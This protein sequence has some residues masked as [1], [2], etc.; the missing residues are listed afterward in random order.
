QAFG[1]LVG[2]RHLLHPEDDWARER[3]EAAL[4][5]SAGADNEW[6]AVGV[7]FAAGHL[8]EEPSYRARA[9]ELLCQLVPRPSERVG[10]AVMAVYQTRDELPLDEAALR[11]LRDVGLHPDILV[12]SG[13]DESFFDHLLDAFVVDPELVCRISEEVVRR[14]G[15]ELQSV[16]QGLY[17]ANS[18]LIDISLRLQR[19]GGDF[20]R[21]GMELFEALLDLG[22]AE[23][24]NVAQNNDLRLIPCGHPIRLP[25]RRRMGSGMK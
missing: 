11:L 10:H 6:V 23:A 12:R 20:R 13:V 2:L 4:S 25:R 9:T 1:E 8:W 17:L 7:A 21:R 22:V 3:V 18:A 15:A 14:R 16:S 5:G 19:S 24:I